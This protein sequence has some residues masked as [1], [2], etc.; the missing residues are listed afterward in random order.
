[1]AFLCVCKDIADSAERRKTHTPAH[2]AYIE[3]VIDRILVAGPMLDPGTGGY[4]A[5]CFIYDTDDEEKA[6]TLL[7]DDPYYRAG[8]YA[9]VHMQPFRPAAGT[10]IGGKTW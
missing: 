1:M 5:S 9:D 2:L 3:S 8:I 4:N 10:W 7:H 6:R